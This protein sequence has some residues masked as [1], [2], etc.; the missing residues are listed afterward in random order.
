MVDIT[1]DNY[2][3]LF[4]FCDHFTFDNRGKASFIGVFEQII[5]EVIPATV[6]RFY[7]PV[8]ISNPKG[9][10]LTL[11]VSSENGF[12]LTLGTVP[13]PQ[14]VKLMRAAWE[15]QNLI[16]SKEE[17]YTFSLI[18]DGEPIAI[19]PLPVIRAESTEQ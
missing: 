19:R 6:T 16:F 13:V 1:Q 17:T 3:A 14:D 18:M 8:N 5:P 4:L 9:K 11:Q 2:V 12:D 7:I 15:M 10:E